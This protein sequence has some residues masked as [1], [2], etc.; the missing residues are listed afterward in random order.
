MTDRTPFV[1]RLHLGSMPRGWGKQPD[2]PLAVF[3]DVKFS[4]KERLSLVGSVGVNAARVN[5]AGCGQIVDQLANI[6]RFATGW[7]A[8][9][10]A[11]L[12]RIWRR[13]HLNDLQAGTPVQMPFIRNN[14]AALEKMM[15]DEGKP[16][17]DIV[18]RELEARGLSPDPAYIH[19]GKPYVYGSA[20]L[21]EHV[22]FD[23]LDFLRA[24]PEGDRANPWRL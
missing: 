18:T 16:W 13:Y 3:V 2:Y 7:D 8:D 21:F 1:R 6:D 9:S 19:N 10:V 24:A 15:R 14:V 11:R 5:S 22:P 12:R 20:W 23:A 17:F 4:D